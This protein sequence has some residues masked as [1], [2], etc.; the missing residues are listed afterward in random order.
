MELQWETSYKQGKKLSIGAIHQYNIHGNNVGNWV[1]SSQSLSADIGPN[2]LGKHCYWAS[3]G[4]SFHPIQILGRIQL[5]PHLGPSFLYAEKIRSNG[6]YYWN[7]LSYE[8]LF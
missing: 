5:S 7:C 1:Y 4:L 8:N 3:V 6:L 2:K